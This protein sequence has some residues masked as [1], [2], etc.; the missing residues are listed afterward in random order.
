MTA[1]LPRDSSR[2]SL[3]PWQRHKLLRELAAGDRTSAQLAADYGMTASGIRE[4]KKRHRP[5]VDAIA[6]DLANEFAG[7]WIADKGQRMSAYQDDYERT[8]EHQHS[9]HHEWVKS[10]TGILH[11]VAEELGQLPGRSPIITVA[12]THILEGVDLEDLT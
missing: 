6:A 4:Y 9:G 5:Q 11:N 10:R 1:L 12:V 7:L 8:L 3:R 2:D